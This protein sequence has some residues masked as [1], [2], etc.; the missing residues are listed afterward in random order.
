MTFFT[1][2]VPFIFFIFIGTVL[3]S[4]VFRGR[5]EHVLARKVFF[6]SLLTYF[7]YGIIAYLSYLSNDGFFQYQDQNHFLEVS[8]HLGD[9]S[10]VYYIY[11]ACFI[12]RIHIENEGAY[13]YVGLIG[14][15][16]NTFLEGNNV[17]IQIVNVSFIAS[18]IPLFVFKILL[19]YV[20]PKVAFKSA[21]AYVFYSY[22]FYYSPWLLRD[23]HI[24]FLYVIGL[25]ILTGSFTKI[26]VMF[27]ILLMLVT[28]MFRL[29]HGIF[30]A[31]IPLLYIYEQVKDRKVL[32]FLM[33]SLGISILAFFARVIIDNLLVINDLLNRYQEF[34]LNS[35]NSDGLG[36]RLLQLPNGIRQIASAIYSQISPFP[37]WNL[38][39]KGNDAFQVII[40]VVQMISPIYWFV[41]W[42]CV[43]KCL[44]IKSFRNSLPRILVILLFV[45]ITFLIANSSNA[46]VRRLMCLY[47]VLFVIYVYARSKMPW[48]VK[49][50]NIQAILLYLGL[51]VL[52][53]FIKV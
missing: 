31:F 30:F 50:S 53:F 34:T 22:T 18:L 16:A 7:V 47:P 9:L 2:T 1:F 21:L 20:S 48:K 40:G 41:V 38:A 32:R 25:T 36:R 13:F 26:R 51:C 10:N 11:K 29:E 24:S 52:Y 39:L 12:D 15:F 37:S 43:I 27:L 35:S 5:S 23:I 33:F 49:K 28:M 17:F 44:M 19:R 14:Y 8:N 42:F 3:S 6:V 45:F 4:L 46:N